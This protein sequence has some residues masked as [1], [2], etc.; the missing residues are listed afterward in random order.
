MFAPWARLSFAVFAVSW[1]AN[2]FAPMQLVYREHL[3]LGSGSFTAML[4]SY[5]LGLIPALLYFG[6]VADRIGRRPVILAMVPVSIVSSVVL[7]LGAELPLLLYLGRVLAGLASGMAF[8]AGTAW[9]KELSVDAGPGVGARRAAVSLSAGFGCGALFAGLIAQWLPAPEVLT[10]VVH[11]ALMAVALV[12]V[13]P[14]PDG[15]VPRTEQGSWRLSILSNPRFRWGVMPWAPWVFGCATVSF[16]TLPP[17]VSD[18]VSE[19]S[20]AF[21]G[22]I[23]ALTLLTGALI[24]PWARRMARHDE[25]LGV[26][27]GVGIGVLG[28]AAGAGTAY[29]DG[30]WSVVVIVA[31]AVL[32]GA[33]YGILLISGLVAV[34]H[35]APADE[36]AQSVAVFYCLIYLGFAVPFVIALAAPHIGFGAC[37]AAAAVL[38][39]AAL[40]FGRRVRI[41]PPGRAH[42]RAHV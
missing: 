40:I 24:Q 15:H 12:L 19:V 29:T 17:L 26:R 21:T 10:Y 1:G 31:A 36:L 39:C 33:G 8:G 4:G 20:I 5:I 38:M 3:G 9:M 35:I 42:R 6:R 34:E 30:P 27:L 18:S 32:L 41:N 25:T 22:M 14:V 28:F 7:L 11:I 23:A 16:V 13:W 2:Q 37:F